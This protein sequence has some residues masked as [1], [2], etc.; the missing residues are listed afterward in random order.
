MLL[1]DYLKN[2]V[3]SPECFSFGRRG[4]TL[5]AAR[6]SRRIC[7]QNLFRPRQFFFPLRPLWP[8]LHLLT[9]H[10]SEFKIQ[11]KFSSQSQFTIL[12][13][14]A[15]VIAGIHKTMTKKLEIIWFG[16]FCAAIPVELGQQKVFNSII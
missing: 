12:V 8:I 13:A 14:V 11:I 3:F 6:S 10:L 16:H 5:T 1:L 4:K 2:F 9:T 7:A 15:D